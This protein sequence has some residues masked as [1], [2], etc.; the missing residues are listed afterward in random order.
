MVYALW[1]K[2]RKHTQSADKMESRTLHALSQSRAEVWLRADGWNFARVNR[3]WC[4]PNLNEQE[5]FINDGKLRT[6]L[7]LSP[8]IM[9][10]QYVA[11]LRRLAGCDRD[12]L[13][14]ETLSK[15]WTH[16]FPITLVPVKTVM[17]YKTS[18]AACGLKKKKSFLW[19]ILKQNFGVYCSKITVQGKIMKP[20]RWH[21]VF[22]FNEV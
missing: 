19:V 4:W 15:Q 16:P 17:C 13:W 20:L 1:S 14:T 6:R 12:I 18:P 8:D 3:E 9:S 22:F 10:W 2:A 5:L 11:Y 7:C 21:S